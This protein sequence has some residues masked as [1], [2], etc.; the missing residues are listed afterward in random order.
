MM[1]ILDGNLKALRPADNH[2]S[3][4]ESWSISLGEALS[5]PQI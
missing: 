3:E 2:M 4:L 5:W 1:S